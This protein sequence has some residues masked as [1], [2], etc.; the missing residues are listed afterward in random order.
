MKN[1]SVSKLNDRFTDQSFFRALPFEWMAAFSLA[2]GDMADALVMGQSMG[3]TGLAAV[4]LALPVF[5]VINLIMHGMGA[6][7]SVHFS[8]LLGNGNCDNAK[9]SFSQVFQGTLVLG[10]FLA[11]MGNLFLTPLMAVLG[12]TAEDGSIYEASSTY[13]RM[14]LT[15]MPLF[16]PHTF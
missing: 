11:L 5:M 12:T 8:K 15:A 7:G 6:G 3:A 14:I 16:L 4:S 10:V 1:R 13:V 2:L 9:R